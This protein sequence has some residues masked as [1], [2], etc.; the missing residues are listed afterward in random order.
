MR[1]CSFTENPSGIQNF[2]RRNP[3]GNMEEPHGRI[4]AITGGSS[5]AEYEDSPFV[6]NLGIHLLDYTVS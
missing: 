4:A 1:S 5:S 3:T 6:N 2:I